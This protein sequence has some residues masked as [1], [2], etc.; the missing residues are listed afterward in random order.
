MAS[1]TGMSPI[2]YGD[3][4]DDDGNDDDNG[5]DDDDGNDGNDGNDN[6]G[7]NDGHGNDNDDGDNDNGKYHDDGK[8][9]CWFK[10]PYRNIK[11][12]EQFKG[13]TTEGKTEE[14][15]EEYEFEL[16]GRESLSNSVEE[17]DP[18]IASEGEELQ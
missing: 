9:D 11:L 13:M 5:N 1:R 10:Q 4:D 15:E 12:N 7:D 6:G 16:Q 8:N 18:D 17:S 3:D 2:N 14:Q